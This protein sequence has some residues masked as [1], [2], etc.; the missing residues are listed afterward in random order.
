MYQLEAPHTH[1]KFRFGLKILTYVPRMSGID[2]EVSMN[3]KEEFARVIFEKY[4]VNTIPTIDW[5]HFLQQ[6]RLKVVSV[7]TDGSDG[8]KDGIQGKLCTIYDIVNPTMDQGSYFSNIYT[9]QIL[10]VLLQQNLLRDIRKV[11]KSPIHK[12]MFYDFTTDN[13]VH[14]ISS[15]YSLQT[16]YYYGKNLKMVL[17][18]IRLRISRIYCS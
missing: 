16:I 11:T 18:A 15:N 2:K 17:R 4:K 13:G 8:K 3:G 1:N 14:V 5:V 7:G 6:T 12:H 10:I 9:L